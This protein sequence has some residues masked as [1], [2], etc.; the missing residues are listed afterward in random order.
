MI[1]RDHPSFVEGIALREQHQWKLAAAAFERVLV[2]EP[3]NALACFWLAVSLDNRG[4]EAAAI[5]NYRRALTSGL[6]GEHRAR[7]W[8]WLA[9]SLSKTGATVAEVREALDAAETEG[10]YAPRDQHERIRVS[11]ERRLAR[12]R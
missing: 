10:G 7:A 1:P 2:D 5:P 8:L 3:A 11:I 12:L 9:S 4:E 6:E